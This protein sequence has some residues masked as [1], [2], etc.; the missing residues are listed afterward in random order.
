MSNVLLTKLNILF[1]FYKDYVLVFLLGAI[2]LFN[3][4]L[5]AKHCLKN[6]RQL[7]SQILFISKDLPVRSL[8]SLSY[9]SARRDQSR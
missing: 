9:T 8:L 4:K 5:A 3:L 1:F 2:V 6:I 7:G